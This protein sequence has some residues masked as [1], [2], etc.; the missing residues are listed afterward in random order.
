MKEY[1]NLAVETVALPKKD[2]M[3]RKFPQLA[4]MEVG[5]SFLIPRNAAT[6]KPITGINIKTVNADTRL[7]GKKFRKVRLPEGVRIYRN[8]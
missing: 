5:Q 1:A 7:A 8:D 4:T 3:V 2:D 6:G